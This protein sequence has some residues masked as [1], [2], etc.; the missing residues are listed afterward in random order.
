MREKN[1]LIQI[2][3]PFIINLVKTLK[4]ENRLY[5]IFEYVP[6]PDLYQAC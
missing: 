3:H 6:G 4:D 2:D 5:F 1:I